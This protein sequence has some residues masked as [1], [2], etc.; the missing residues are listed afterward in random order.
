MTIYKFQ[1]FILL[2]LPVA[3]LTG[4]FLA[5][6]SVSII[7]LLFIFSCFFY[8]NSKYL[9][10]KF[11]I[12]LFIWCGIILF[13]SII[14]DHIMLSLESSLF[15]SRFVFF[16]L[17][18]WFVLDKD[19]KFIK[20][21]SIFFLITFIFVVLDSYLQYFTQYNIFGFYYDGY[22]LT[23]VFNDKSVLGNYISRLLPFFFGLI[24]YSYSQNKFSLILSITVLLLAD[25]LI[26]LSGERTSIFLTILGTMMIIILL[27][28]NKLIRVLAFIISFLFAS[29]IIY[30]DENI[31]DRVITSTI[32]ETQIFEEN[33]KVFSEG[34]ELLYTTGIEMFLDNPVFG[35]GPKNYRE[36]CKYDSYFIEVQTDSSLMSNCSTHPHNSYIQLLSETGIFG[37]VPFLIFFSVTSF[38]ALRHLISF[39]SYRIK[40]S[41]DDFQ[42]CLLVTIFL[43]LW[44]FAPTMNLFNNWISVIYFLP[45]GFLLQAFDKKTNN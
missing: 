40:T 24:I 15:Y 44:P 9:T 30:F 39:F 35:I 21:F 5:D 17:G 33:K 12:I 41:L 13:S 42:V 38:I 2:F 1:S 25:T 14:S 29:L 31:K 26:V 16:S 22:R 34:H 27:K 43:T 32:N 36:V 3:I 20:K 6:L 28:K 23:G 10:N 7:A 45:V 8:D 19:K 37:I 18:V 4:P 11:I